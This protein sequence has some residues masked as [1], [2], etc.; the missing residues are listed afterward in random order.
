MSGVGGRVRG[1]FAGTSPPGNSAQAAGLLPTMSRVLAYAA[2]LW[3]PLLGLA[4][5]STGSPAKTSAEPAAPAVAAAPSPVED[6][7]AS[8]TPRAPVSTAGCPFQWEPRDLGASVVRI[9]KELAGRFM[10]PLY[11][12]A[13]ACVRPGEQVYIVARIVPEHGT[14][15]ATTVPREDIGTKADPSIDACISTVLG[16]TRFEPFELGSD[17]IC[18][19]P[20][21]PPET[22]GPPFFRPPRLANCPQGPQTSKINYPLLVD[23]RSEARATAPAGG[24]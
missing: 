16:P 19:E 20:P 13:C 4:C 10:N 3:L 8:T 18:P 11:D 9:P 12:L 14:T 22:K 24:S 7:P 5:T 15:E 21:P 6:P 1:V 17:V 23:R 2:A